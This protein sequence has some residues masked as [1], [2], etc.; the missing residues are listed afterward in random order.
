MESLWPKFEEQ[1]IE[2]NDSIQI[3]REQAR[4]IKSETNGI[5]HETKLSQ[6]ISILTRSFPTMCMVQNMQYS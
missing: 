3:L 5:I 2:Q 6:Y 1:I 4:A